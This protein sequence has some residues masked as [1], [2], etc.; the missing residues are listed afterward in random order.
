MEAWYFAICL[1]VTRDN[2]YVVS[3]TLLNKKKKKKKKKNEEEEEEE[4]WFL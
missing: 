2:G 1:A 3:D 4:D